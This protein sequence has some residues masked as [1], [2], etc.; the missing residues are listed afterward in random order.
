MK[1]G[2][3]FLAFVLILFLITRVYK[4]N[5]IPP[6]FYWDEASIGYNAYSISID[7]KDEWGKFLPLHFR[8][9]GEFKLPV[10]IYA[11]AILIKIFGYGDFN[12]RLTAV[13]F[14][15]LT[16]IVTFLMGYKLT[17]NLSV[18]VLGAFFV[19]ISPW[20]YI[21]SRTGY[22]ANAGLAFYSLGIYVFLLFKD[23]RE[24]LRKS[25][26][27]FVSV[28]MFILS[29]YSYNSFRVVVPIAIIFLSFPLIRYDYSK[30][31]IP[32]LCLCAFLLLL[33]FVPIFKLMTDS[34]A[35]SR[36]ET[37]SIFQQNSSFADTSQQFLKNYLAHFTPDFL[38]ISGDKNLR[39]HQNGFG[40]LYVIDLFFILGG[41]FFIVKSNDP[42]QILMLFL[43]LI[44][45]IPAAFTKE[46]PHAL[47][48][49]SAVPFIGIINAISIFNVDKKFSKEKILNKKGFLILIFLLYLLS[50]GFLLFNFNTTYPV[51]SSKDWQYGYK[52]IVQSYKEKFRDYQNIV[53]SDE[54]GQPY[55]F[56]VYYLKYDPKMF[57][58]EVSYNPPQKWG[59][60]L[61]NKF[62]KFLFIKLDGINLPKGRSLIFDDKPL[63]NFQTKDVVRNLDNSIAFYVY[64]INK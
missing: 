10:F 54:Y 20:F 49:I 30:K 18:G 43:L 24:I 57:R 9:F 52:Q 23:Q 33:S 56:F 3:L 34:F 35:T 53:V 40:Q 37:V 5:Q 47:R 15:L 17:K 31:I 38:F 8:A 32:S 14:S 4:I 63:N 61:V 55:I 19:V 22:E 11:N 29:A 12:V 7:G 6:S 16:V 51:M 21:F 41:C 26:Y 59:F 13:I 42:S 39:S 1:K 64:E 60:S 28:L 50:F 46:S 25:L 48:S 45:F 62:D 58:A 36:F 2:Y 44:S 27:L